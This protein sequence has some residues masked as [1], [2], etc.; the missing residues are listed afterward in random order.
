LSHWIRSEAIQKLTRRFGVVVDS[1]RE[2]PHHNIPGKKLNWKRECE[3]AG[4]LFFVLRKREIENYLHPDAIVRT[5]HKLKPYD[6][7]TDMKALFGPNIIKV[8]REMSAE[9][10]LE[11]DRYEEDGVSR[12]ELKEIVEALLALPGSWP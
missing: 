12:H 2:N 5:G 1:D 11:S 3:R 9:E 8:I 4:G 7:F 10:I 6:D